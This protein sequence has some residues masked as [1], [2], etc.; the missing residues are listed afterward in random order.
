MHRSNTKYALCAT[1]AIAETGRRTTA[2]ANISGM[3]IHSCMKQIH[4]HQYSYFN[5]HRSNTKYA[6]C[7]TVAITETGRRTT[8]AA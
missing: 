2:A 4:S 5:M 3:T 7:A 1:V 6:L 8:A